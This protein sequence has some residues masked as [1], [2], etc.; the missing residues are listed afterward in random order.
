LRALAHV[1][2]ALRDVLDNKPDRDPYR[3]MH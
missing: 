2:R 1:E 3:R